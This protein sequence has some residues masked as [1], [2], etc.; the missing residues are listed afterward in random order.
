MRSY[1]FMI[2]RDKE[3]M[4]TTVRTTEKNVVV[5][6]DH[7]SNIKGLYRLMEFQEIGSTDHRRVLRS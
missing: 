6:S 7:R 3:E 2:K 4:T 1:F 5:F